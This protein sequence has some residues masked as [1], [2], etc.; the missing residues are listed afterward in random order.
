MTLK[1]PS[2]IFGK[3]PEDLNIKIVEKNNSLH[4]ELVKVENLSDQIIQLQQELSQKVIQSD[5]EELFSSQIN[6]IQENFENLQNDFK[7]SNKRDIKN[8]N[9]LKDIVSNTI[10]D[11]KEEVYNIVGLLSNNLEEYS[12]ELSNIRADV[13]IN[14]HHINSVN[15]YFKDGVFSETEKLTSNNLKN[16]IVR[17]EKKIDF[18][19]ETYSKI[20]PEVIIRE[21]INQGLLNEPPD[22]NNS[23]P[24][25]PLDKNF[26]TLEQLQQHYRL[27]LNRIQQQMSTIGGGGETRLKYLDDIVGISTNSSSYDQK[28][29]KYDHSIQKFIF[30]EVSSSTSGIATYASNA[31][32]ATYATSAGIATYASNAGIATF[33]TSAGIATYASNAGIATYAT[34]AGIATYATS[35]G[36]ATY[37]SN[38]GIATYATSAGIATYAS[39]A[40]IATY[41]SNAGIATYATSAGIATYASNAGI[42]TN[43]QGLTGTP[44]LNVGIIT[45]TSFVGSGTNLTGIVT[46]IVAGTNVTIS[47]ST[48][49][50]TINASGGSSSQFVTTAAGIHTL[51]NVG[52]G[53]TNPTSALTVSGDVKVTGII[54]AS[55]FSGNATSATYATSAGIA[56]Y[57]SNAGIATYSSNAGIATYASNAGIAT[58]ATSA[59][60]A[61]YAS[62]AGI[63]TYSSNAGIATFATS[64]GIATNAQGLTGT[65]NLN[66]GIVTATSFV[67]DG[68]FLTGIVGSGSGIV[69]KDSGSTVGTAGTIDFGDNLTVSAI[70]AGIVTVTGSA[71]GGSGIGLSISDT[72]PANTT[73]YPLWYSSLI[74]RGFVYYDDGSSSQWVDFSPSSIAISAGIATYA[75]NAGIATYATNAGIAT[76][77]TSSGIA[78]N[79]QGLTGT[80]NLNVGIITATSFVGNGSGLT[81]LVGVSAGIV[82]KDSGSTVGTAGTIDFGDN[83]TVSAISAGIV[84]V[85]GSASGG[86][87]SQFVTTA[88]GIHT[89]S[90]VGIGTTNPTSKL[91]VSGDALI[92]GLT[93]GRGGSAE[94]T[95]TAIGSSALSSNTTGSDNVAN[96]YNA[97][98]SNTTADGNVAN[99]A[100]AL[101]LTTNG[102]Y[103]V[104]IGNGSLF[105][106]T[107]GN[108]NT[109]TG[110][111][112]LNSNTTS[113][114]N[115]ATGNS[116]LYYNTGNTNVAVGAYAGQYITTGSKN[117]I[118]G[119]YTGNQN[120]LDIRTSSNNVVL[121]DGD[122]N[123]RFYANSSGNVGLGTT[124]PKGTLQVGTGITMYGSTGI[125]SATTFYGNVV[126]NISGSITDATNLTGGYANASQ[127][128]VSGVTTISQGRIQ[129]DGS[130]NLRFGNL[131]AGSGS[132]RN[133]A[134]GDQVLYS[135]SSGQ[136]RNI[137]IGEL[138]YYDTTSGQYNIGL[139]IQ[140]GQKITTGNYNVILGGYDGQTGLDIRTS[141]NNVVIADGQGNIRQYINSS[142]NVGI[143][144]TVITEALTVAG[145]VSATSFYG[146]LNAGHLT[147]SLPAIDG[148]ALIGVVGSGSGIIIEEDGTPVGTAGT[149]NFGSN[150]NVAFASGI[151]TVSGS[152]LATYANVAGIATYATTAG[153]STTSGTANYATNAGVS[154]TSGTA[155]YATTAGISSTVSGTININTTGIITASSFSGSGSGLTN[156]PAAQLTGTLPAIDGS[157]LLNVTAAGTGI[158][159]RDD[160]ASVGS[161]TT[162]NFGTGLDVTFS[163]GIATITASGG[164]L[165][166][167]TTV[168]GVTTSIANLGIGNTNITG[169]KSYALMKVGLSTTGWL[170]LYTDS[171]SRANDVSR[172]VG[173]DPA[174][175]SGVIAE[176]VTTG[177]STTQIISPFVMGGNLDNS[178]TT[179]IYAAITNLSGTT[180][181]ITA[182]LTILQLEA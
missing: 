181:A 106:N 98:R 115:N 56:T 58:F 36:I 39:N 152:G 131:A 19:R 18:I 67:G 25:T 88:A 126:G 130:S 97:L 165:Q 37:A 179:T 57:S 47:G 31:G 125:I 109:A 14:E 182:N 92:N 86:G 32:I 141:S 4:D 73:S 55:S 23:D 128:N 66:V 175:G 68:S 71:S 160:N 9:E 7:K 45:A 147:G 70:S 157:A 110:R 137:G 145:I 89:L 149:I 151:A 79:A 69:V 172:S 177:I 27:F 117:T 168:S 169:F 81:N 123:I 80:P 22:T 15:K 87:S 94:I 173:E 140:A 82:I 51:S 42:A 34:S 136:G 52:I 8:F 64:A 180:Q 148:S 113:S 84:T 161:A 20:E 135:L 13:I 146:T 129:A 150:I 176:V 5:L 153:V 114:N 35:A 43:A 107:T 144:T 10:N 16:N 33:A 164:S 99:G 46:S 118:L 163:A 6:N 103:N 158:A 85:T 48:G 83:L 76:Y 50:V 17:L 101:L 24:L 62:N 75:T 77:A 28:F 142:G 29:L 21:A 65:P 61:T 49:Q 139:G 159:V 44:N 41:A 108:F 102:S 127:L 119:S 11:V 133:I 112:T 138:S 155:G 93:V 170:R 116:A 121:S 1:K 120:G 78:T 74:G 26:V 2:D 91:T 166:S 3:K 96:G 171:T 143:K 178:P 38:A 90:N 60:I 124:N 162:V 63:A 72:P 174:P 167:R 104:A 111:D 54:T 59:G 12:K 122:G 134:I 154:T 30:S 53:T 105:S 132:G 40:G 95:N 156:L 100:N